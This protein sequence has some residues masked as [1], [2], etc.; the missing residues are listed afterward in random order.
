MISGIFLLFGKA[1]FGPK[2]PIMCLEAQQRYFSYRAL[3]VA[4]RVCF[5]FFFLRGASHKMVARYAAK[6]GIAQMCLCETKYKGDMGPLRSRD[7]C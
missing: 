1:S 5:F 3:L 7:G 6:L 2:D 4:I